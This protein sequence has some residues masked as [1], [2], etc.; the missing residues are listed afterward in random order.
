LRAPAPQLRSLVSQESAKHSLVSFKLIVQGAR[1]GDKP[2]VTVLMAVHNGARH[3]R[4]SVESILTQTYSDFE[5]LIVDDGSTDGTADILDS[6]ADSRIRLLQNENNL[7]LSASLNR[8]LRESRGGLVARQDADDVSE[9]SRIERQVAFMNAH[10]SIAVVGTAY[11]K[12]NGEGRFIANRALPPD[13]LTLRWHLLFYCP[14][15]HGSV[16]FRRRAADDL[17]GYDTNLV[18]SMDH[19]L[20][21]RLA[22]RRPVANLPDVLF[23]YR[24]WDG[25][26]TATSS[27]IRT[28]LATVTTQNRRR[29]L[30]NAEEVTSDELDVKVASPSLLE[31]PSRECLEMA[32]HYARELLRLQSAFAV[33]Y[34][35]SWR[36]RA[37]HRAEVCSLVGMQLLRASG[38]FSD[39]P[40]HRLARWLLCEAR[41][42]RMLGRGRGAFRQSS[43]PL[44]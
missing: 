33:F 44:R 15:V 12:I 1:A 22:L 27:S 28:E 37:S 31:V 41:A 42:L 20:W 32:R 3:L 26:L 40:T 11:R 30:P 39:R 9:P 23:Q 7:G 25:S 43:P 13:P 18:Y 19:D 38:T 16:I 36:D 8:G 14:F 5:F 35:L 10:P 17:N 34:D 29:V 2:T 4:D 21:S 24:V 6:F